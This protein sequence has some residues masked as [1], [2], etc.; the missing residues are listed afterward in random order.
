[1]KVKI[2]LFFFIVFASLLIAPTVISLTDSTKDIA[3]FIDMNEEEENKGKESVIYSELK[4]QPLEEGNYFI[5]NGIQKKKNIRFKSKNYTSEFS[6]NTTP[7]PELL[8]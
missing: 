4:I 5:F 1:M 2:A 7:P 6:K 8:S 3:F